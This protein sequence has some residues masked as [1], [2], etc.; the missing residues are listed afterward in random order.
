MRTINWK[1]DLNG[2]DRSGIEKST[3]TKRKEV[4]DRRMKKIEIKMKGAEALRLD[5][6]PNLTFTDPTLSG[7]TAQTLGLVQTGRRQR[8]LNRFDFS[9]SDQL[10][11]HHAYKVHPNGC[12]FRRS[13]SDAHS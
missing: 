10:G 11:F 2:K 12:R 3:S 9:I 6:D 4:D 1:G 8:I 13:G 7:E 5:S